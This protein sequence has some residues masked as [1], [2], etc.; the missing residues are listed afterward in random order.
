M[1]DWLFRLLITLGANF[2]ARFIWLLGKQLHTGIVWLIRKSRQLQGDTE[3]TSSAPRPCTSADLEE[4]LGDFLEKYRDFQ[5]RT[6]APSKWEFLLEMVPDM[7][8]LS[9]AILMM[10]VERMFTSNEENIR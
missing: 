3:A 5:N 4:L 7:V 9:K 2:L 1:E 10:A 6:P 8:G